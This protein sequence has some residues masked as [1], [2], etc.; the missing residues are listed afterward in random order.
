MQRIM[1]LMI[2]VL[3]CTALGFRFGMDLENRLKSLK[4]F[5][6]IMLML[7]GEIQY[8]AASLKEAFRILAEQVPQPFCEFLESTAR[9]MEQRD[10][11]TMT[12]ILEGNAGILRGKTG[13]NEKDIRSFVRAGGRLGYLDTEMQL[14]TI[15]L[16]LE[17]LGRELKAAE[18]EYQ[19][20]VRVYRCLGFMGGLFLAVIFL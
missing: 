12:A 7:R 19:G 13:L 3:S 8:A 4:E 6:K 17:E 9:D 11:K 10:G 15:D 5:Q 18:E 1:G 2:T 16:Y 20:K 14:R